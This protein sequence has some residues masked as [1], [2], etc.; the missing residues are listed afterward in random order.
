MQS[1]NA[2]EA[3]EMQQSPPVPAVAA[4]RERWT[5]Q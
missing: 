3:D 1:N 5:A 2:L 4:Q